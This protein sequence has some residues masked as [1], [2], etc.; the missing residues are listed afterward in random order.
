MLRFLHHALRSPR[1]LF[2]LGAVLLLLEAA[3]GLHMWLEG[4]LSSGRSPLARDLPY[5]V[6]LTTSGTSL[7]LVGI[8]YRRSETIA[9]QW[10]ALFWRLIEI[11]SWWILCVTWWTNLLKWSKLLWS[12]TTVL[13][14]ILFIWNTFQ[15][16]WTEDL[17][18]VYVVT[19]V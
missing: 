7:L 1:P 12:G 8:L 11:Y 4:R 2:C 10:L 5:L 6:A 14:D 3:Y 15:I 9:K 18:I 13:F 17:T 16:F 19:K